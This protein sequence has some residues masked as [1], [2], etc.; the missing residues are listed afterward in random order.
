MVLLLFVDDRALE[1][2]FMTVTDQLTRDTDKL[3]K[4]MKSVRLLYLDSLS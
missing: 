2:F 1:A 3:D 4:Q